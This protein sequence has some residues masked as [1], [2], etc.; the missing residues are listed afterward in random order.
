LWVNVRLVHGLRP[1]SYDLTAIRFALK[2]SP[3]METSQ[4]LR[5]TL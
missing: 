2:L 1:K 5:S 3:P 4:A